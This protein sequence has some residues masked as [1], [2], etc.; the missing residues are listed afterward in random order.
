MRLAAADINGIGTQAV[1]RLIRSA[2]LCVW[3]VG[4]NSMH[5][6]AADTKASGT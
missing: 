6:A 1:F 3:F 2:Y 4:N 5:V